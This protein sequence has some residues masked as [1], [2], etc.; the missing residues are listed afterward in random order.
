VEILTTFL[1][2]LKKY[3]L[4][5][6]QLNEGI[7]KYIEGYRMEHRRG[8]KVDGITYIN[9]NQDVLIEDGN[10]NKKSNTNKII[11]FI[12]SWM[13]NKTRSRFM[14]PKGVDGEPTYFN[15]FFGEE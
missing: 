3:G 9:E 5:N 8:E 4:N 1:I 13:D 12:Q 11:Y 6:E 15:D 2:F 14:P 10:E 7:I